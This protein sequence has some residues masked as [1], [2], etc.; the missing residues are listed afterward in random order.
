M[1]T[2]LLSALLRRLSKELVADPAN[3]IAWAQI[4]SAIEV[5]RAAEPELGRIVDA[6]DA[7]ALAALV[8]KWSSGEAL[9]PEHDRAT[10]KSAVKAFKK[11]LKVTRLDD[12]SGIGGGAMSSGK[13]SGIVAIAPPA[14]FAQD[15]WD[16]LVRQGKLVDARHGIYE[17]RSGAGDD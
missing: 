10:L 13:K 12:E 4:S 6:R 11:S 17:L 9:L 16:E 5:A 1:H 2:A 8:G 7:A 3:A 14:R 15:V